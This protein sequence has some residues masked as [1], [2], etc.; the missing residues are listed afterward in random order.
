MKVWTFVSSLSIPLLPKKSDTQF[1]HSKVHSDD[2]FTPYHLHH[3]A[4]GQLWPHLVLQLHSLKQLT[5]PILFTLSSS[6]SRSLVILLNWC[7]LSAQNPEPPHHTQVK[8]KVLSGTM[9]SGLLISFWCLRLLPF[10]SRLTP[11][12]SNILTRHVPLSGSSPFHFLFSV[13]FSQMSSW[14]TSH[15]LQV[16]VLKPADRLVSFLGTYLTWQCPPPYALIT[17]H[18][19]SPLLPL[20][21]MTFNAVISPLGQK[22]HKR[23][24]FCLI[25]SSLYLRAQGIAGDTWSFPHFTL[26]IWLQVRCSNMYIISP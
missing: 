5:E 11:T 7:H 20:H 9:E 15:F 2:H 16:F 14:L 24:G 8:A 4:A 10:L 21:R 1:I 18:P 23:Q 12:S 19:T 17:F 6:Q 26:S 13:T 22:C 25:S 3:L